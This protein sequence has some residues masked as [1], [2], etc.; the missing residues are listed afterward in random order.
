M[1]A[2]FLLSFLIGV[3]FVAFYTW[4][5]S[6]VELKIKGKHLQHNVEA[7]VVILYVVIPLLFFFVFLNFD[8]LN[9]RVLVNLLTSMG[10]FVFGMVIE[11]YVTENG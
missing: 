6:P 7:A 5:L 10:G 11:H 3:V 9:L 2:R 8:S 1:I 4:L